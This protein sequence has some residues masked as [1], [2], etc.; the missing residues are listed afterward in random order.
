MHGQGK[1]SLENKKFSRSGKS[2]A[3]LGLVRKI[4]KKKKKKKKKMGKVKEFQNFVKT[5]IWQS[6][7]FSETDKFTEYCPH[8]LVKWYLNS[9]NFLASQIVW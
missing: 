9:R 5:G 7:L 1:K 8:F 4:G 3:R 6:S 2:Q